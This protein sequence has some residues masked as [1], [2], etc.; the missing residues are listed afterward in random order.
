MPGFETLINPF[1]E[2]ESGIAAE[3]AARGNRRRLRVFLVVFVSVLVS[4][5]VFTF[6]RPAEYRAQ[7]RI[8]VKIA[9]S[10]T[11]LPSSVPRSATVTTAPNA[12]ANSL[13]TEAG[14]LTSRPLIETAL[15]TLQKQDVAMPE[16]GSDPVQG[17]QDALSAEPVADT[18]IVHLTVVGPKPAHL[19]AILNAL[20]DAYT[21]KV[22]ESYASSASTEVDALREELQ[23]LNQRLAEKRKALEEYRQTAD[24]VSGERDENQIL[25]R[26][27][28]LSASLNVVNE[29]VAQAEGRVR[30]IRDSLAAGK[31]MVRSRDNPT[32]AALESR[33]S[34]LRE[35][36]REQERTYTPQFM[37]MDPNVRGM[38]SRLADLEVQIAEQK[39]HSGQLLLSE[40]EE[41][42]ATARQS[43]QKLQAQIAEDRR[44]VHAFSKSFSAFKSME[45]E[46]SQIEA[47]RS[48]LSERLLRTETS[49]KSRKPSVQVVEAAAVPQEAWRPNYA[50]DAG[51]S[52]A[53]AFSLGLLALAV[54]ELFN[55]APLPSTGA[56]IMPPSWIT[57]G[58]DLPPMLAGGGERPPVL[59]PANAPAL[60]P[61]TMD[62]SRELSPPEVT[63]LL[64]AMQEEDVAWAV[65]LLC[66]ATLEEIRSIA[67]SDLEAGSS[68]VRL[69]GPSPRTLRIPTAMFGM[70]EAASASADDGNDAVIDVPDSEEELK[71]RLLYAAHDSGLDNPAGITPQTLRH[72]CIAY[73]IRQGLRFSDLDRVV[74]PL[75]ADALAAYA[76]LSPPGLRRTIEEIAPLMPA[77]EIPG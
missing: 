29:K 16:F 31:A 58:Q 54:V 8:A 46:L 32:L 47:S 62:L 26:V 71:R 42:L 43:Q 60:L 22:A 15:A 61:E 2:N 7:A 39:A 4:G 19:A 72:T 35:T 17:I 13:Q 34:Q 10:V 28:G 50:L 69:R 1:R 23:N 20:I 38:R 66:G 55:R 41:E 53:V 68:S 65:M 12:S 27:K 25:A 64:Q 45:L 56:V 75:P 51:I 3:L 21:Q 14:I 48:S 59:R 5:L 11:G 52:V 44:A 57:V 74:G 30:S 24:I 49:E 63:K 18:N 37:A 70:L 73:L 9:G 77:L 6:S 67:P 40:A 36:L 76:S 33:A